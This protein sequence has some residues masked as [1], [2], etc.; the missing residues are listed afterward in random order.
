MSRQASSVRS[1][2]PAPR[3]WMDR[4]GARTS[5]CPRAGSSSR[6]V[7]SPDAPRMRRVVVS[8]AMAPPNHTPHDPGEAVVAKAGARWR[9]PSDSDA[10]RMPGMPEPIED[11]A[12]LSN[13][14]TAAL[15]SRSGSVDWLC[16]PRYDSGSVFAALLGD[17]SH[18]RW[19]LRPTDPTA[20][21]HRR[22]NGETLDR[23][24]TRL[25]SSH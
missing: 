3:R 5:S 11:Y 4:P 8:A 25:N 14:R 13:C 18:G 17:E 23:K 9:L 24:S 20:R 1:S 21:A 6:D 10:E 22:Y 19:G 16:L 15:V 7:R 2:I 12:L